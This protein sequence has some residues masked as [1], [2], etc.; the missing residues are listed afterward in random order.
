M[1]FHGPHHASEEQCEIVWCSCKVEDGQKI[2]TCHH[3]ETKDHH[4]G[5][6][7]DSTN[8]HNHETK[9]HSS[10]QNAQVLDMNESGDGMHCV[11]KHS[12]SYP[13]QLLSILSFLQIKGLFQ[14][15]QLFVHN[16][17]WTSLVIHQQ[18]PKVLIWVDDVYRPP[19]V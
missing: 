7:Q 12:H 2:C 18:D 6:G 17:I 3:N 5:D 19:Q 15:Q 4:H 11:I 16:E 8:D 9:Q 1:T 10:S 13:P 14:S